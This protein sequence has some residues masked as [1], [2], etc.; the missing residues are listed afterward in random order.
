MSVCFL[1]AAVKNGMSPSEKLM[2]AASWFCCY[3]KFLR[4]RQE[5]AVYIDYF[6]PPAET[7]FSGYLETSHH[8]VEMLLEKN[9][10]YGLLVLK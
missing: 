6:F 2:Q 3:W 10:E 7:V 5:V 4:H 9:A 1:G 8:F